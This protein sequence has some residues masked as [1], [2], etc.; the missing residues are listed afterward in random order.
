MWRKHPENASPE[1]WRDLLETA[2]ALVRIADDHG[3]T[4]ALEAEVVT[5]VDSAEKAERLI[6]EIGSPRLRVL[7]DPANL[8]RPVDLPDTKPRLSEG[9]ARLAPYIAIAH[10]KDIRVRYRLH[11]MPSHLSGPGIARLF[12]IPAGTGNL[13]I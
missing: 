9:L 13:R 7:F 11:E 1:A 12:D 10:A 2:N 4:V 8:I 3:L 6:G 5:V